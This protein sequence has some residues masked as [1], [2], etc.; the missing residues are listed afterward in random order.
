MIPVFGPD[1]CFDA[2]ARPKIVQEKECLLS[3]CR[4]EGKGWRVEGGG[5]VPAALLPQ[6]IESVGIEKEGRAWH[7]PGCDAIAQG[8]QPCIMRNARLQAAV[9]DARL[10]AG[11][12]PE[13]MP[14]ARNKRRPCLRIS[15]REQTTPKRM[16]RV[17]ISLQK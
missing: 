2:T 17:T 12:R 4:A 11:G 14:C 7:A 13:R 15:N 1:C 5:F 9:F 10:N 8:K 16:Q 6:H 3:T